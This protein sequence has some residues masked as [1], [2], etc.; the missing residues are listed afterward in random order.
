V[1]TKQDRSDNVITSCLLQISSI[2]DAD[3]KIN[4]QA[5]DLSYCLNMAVQ[6]EIIEITII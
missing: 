1:K 4:K 3:L 5:H 2:N 6:V